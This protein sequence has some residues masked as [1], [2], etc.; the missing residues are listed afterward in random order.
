MSI[1]IRNLGTNK[2]LEKSC[3]L[4]E[5]LLTAP[6]ITCHGNIS[7]AEPSLVI[8][9]G[10]LPRTSL[11]ISHFDLFPCLLLSSTIKNASSNIFTLGKLKCE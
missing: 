4:A 5:T 9:K 3:L 1:E 11:Y 10:E 6:L 2:P 8:K 7:I